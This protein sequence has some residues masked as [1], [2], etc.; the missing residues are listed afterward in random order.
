MARSAREFLPRDRERHFPYLTRDLY[1][2]KSVETPDY[3][4]IAYAAGEENRWWW[5]DSSGVYYWPNGVTREETVEA[6]VEMFASFGY[7]KCYREDFEFGFEKVAIYHTINGNP[8]ALPKSPTHA[9]RM[10]EYG[11]WKSKLG[12]W[13]DIEHKT[14]TC[15]N[16]EDITGRIQPYGEP[17]QIMKR[18][19][20]LVAAITGIIKMLWNRL[21]N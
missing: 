10:V 9:A 14:L 1:E 2:V 8:D 20:G 16:G 21:S 12:P 3:N 7:V 13:Q 5:P 18:R 17:I 19:F 4:C 6:F 11:V 15:L